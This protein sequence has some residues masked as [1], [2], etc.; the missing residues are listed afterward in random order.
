MNNLT[1]NE[2]ILLKDLKHL[3]NELQQVSKYDLFNYSKE[4]MNLSEFNKSYKSLVKKG[5]ILYDQKKEYCDYEGFVTTD[6]G[7]SRG[8]KEDKSDKINR[9]LI[10]CAEEGTFGELMYKYHNDEEML[11]ND[12]KKLIK[13]GYLQRFF[14]HSPKQTGTIIRINEKASI[15]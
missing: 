9:I 15:V 14:V 6:K 3:T 10:V 12:I 5:F 2:E 1:F 13:K 4:F 7:Y 8:L 11:V